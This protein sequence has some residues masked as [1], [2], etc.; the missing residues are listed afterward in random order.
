MKITEENILEEAQKENLEVLK[1]EFVDQVKDNDGNTPLHELAWRGKVEVL[2]HPSVDKVKDN[3]GNTPLHWLAKEG[4]IEVLNHPSVDQVKN[5]YGWT[6]LHE[7]AWNGK[8]TEEYIKEK[9]PWF[10]VGKRKVDLKLI[11]EILNTP[12][13]IRFIKED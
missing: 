3:N 6:P 13:S 7:L 2:I 9:Y 5:N 12:Q 1:S 10:Q 4:K 8:I 11:T